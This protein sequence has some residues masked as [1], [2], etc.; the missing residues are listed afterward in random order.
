MA[1]C[2]G[3]HLMIIMINKVVTIIMIKR[4]TTSK[5]V[6]TIVMIKRKTTSKKVARINT[7]MIIMTFEMVI[8]M[9]MI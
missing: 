9:I 7:I 5:K 1:R 4:M 6:V 2:V 3:G 8:T